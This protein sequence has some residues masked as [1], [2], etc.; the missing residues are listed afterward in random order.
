M[1]I[2]LWMWI[3]NGLINGLING[4]ENKRYGGLKEV[5]IRMWPSHPTISSPFLSPLS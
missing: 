2:M 1:W 4:R 3:N 5:K